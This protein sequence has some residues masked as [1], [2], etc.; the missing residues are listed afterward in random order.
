MDEDEPKRPRRRPGPGP[1]EGASARRA[2]G[3]GTRS[4]GRAR[5]V[6]PEEPEEPDEPVTCWPTVRLTEATVPAMVEVR[7]ASASAVCALVTWVWAESTLA[8]SEAI[9]ADDG[10]VGLVRGQL[11]LVVG[12]E[13]WA[14]ARDARQRGVV[15]GGQGLPGGD[16]LARGHVDGG[17]PPGL[18]EVEAG[19]AGGFDGARGGDRLG[20]GPGRDGLHDGGRGD[21]RRGARAAGGRPDPHAGTGH[22]DHRRDDDGG[23]PREPLLRLAPTYASLVSSLTGSPP[24]GAASATQQLD[25]PATQVGRAIQ[26]SQTLTP[27]NSHL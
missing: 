11:G 26:T 16:G 1:G 25:A 4:R 6:V 27:G 9:W 18:A 2:G 19:L 14:W 5:G 8:W 22:H 21:Q 13:A 17:D 12:Q 24:G 7:V 10:P 23:P 3:P 15:D 20:D